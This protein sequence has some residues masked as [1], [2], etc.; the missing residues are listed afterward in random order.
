M[1]MEEKIK[2]FLREDAH[3]TNKLRIY[4]RGGKKLKKHDKLISLILRFQ[5]ERQDDV[6]SDLYE[7]GKEYIDKVVA[8]FSKTRSVIKDD[9]TSS[10]NERLWSW[11]LKVDVQKIKNAENALIYELKKAAIDIVRG[12]NGTYVERHKLVD[13]TAE[14]N[15]A[16]FESGS[17]YLM[18]DY[19]ISKIDRDIKTDQDKRQLIE[20]LT[21]NSCSLTTAIVKEHLTS[22]KP[23][24]KSV[25]DRVGID[26]KKAK[27][28]VERLAKNYDASLYGD[29]N[30]YLAV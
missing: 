1:V 12:R 26:R 25:A 2:T 23:T 19:V 9:L 6:F 4:N 7:S 21:E 16:T 11:S 8:D 27:R 24:W 18:E 5:K 30:A 22:Q 29:I 20:A 3:K 14:E 13:S 10:L 15:A 28:V 17:D